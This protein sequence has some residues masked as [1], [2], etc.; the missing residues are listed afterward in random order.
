[1]RRVRAVRTR[2]LPICRTCPTAVF[3]TRCPGQSLVEDGDLLGPSRAAC[4][5]AL[6]AARLAGSTAVPAGLAS[7][8]D[9]F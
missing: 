5:Q 8:A 3:C 1:M 2:D 4:E 7:D 6:V 9:S